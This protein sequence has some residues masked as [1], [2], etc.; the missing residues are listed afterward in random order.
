[1]SNDDATMSNY[2]VTQVQVIMA[3]ALI[4]YTVASFP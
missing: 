1:M 4:I 3:T 2:D